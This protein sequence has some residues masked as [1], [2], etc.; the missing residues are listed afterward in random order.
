MQI[1]QLKS[2]STLPSFAV[3]GVH[4]YWLLFQIEFLSFAVTGGHF[5]W[6]LFQIAFLSF[7]V[8]GGHLYWIL[9]QIAFLSLPVSY[10]GSNRIQYRPVR[11]SISLRGLQQR[12]RDSIPTRKLL[13]RP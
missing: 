10:V 4:L 2:R 1:Y 9:F 7:A 3:T 6:L 8:T 13:S 12:N 5:Y 11:I